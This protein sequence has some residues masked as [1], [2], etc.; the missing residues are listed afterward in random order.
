M[1][2]VPL[3]DLQYCAPPPRV[4]AHILKFQNKMADSK[5]DDGNLSIYFDDE[6]MSIDEENF[7]LPRENLIWIF[8]GKGTELLKKVLKMLSLGIQMDEAKLA[9]GILD[10][11]QNQSEA[12]KKS[13]ENFLKEISVTFGNCYEKVEGIKC[14]KQNAIQLEKLITDLP[15]SSDLLKT[16]WDCLINTG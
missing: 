13:I 12:N 5:S 15:N 2:M 9:Q 4:F 14:P 8:P 10:F 11:V 1:A 16:S 7:L 6:E 3:I